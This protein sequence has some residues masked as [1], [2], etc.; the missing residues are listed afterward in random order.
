MRFILT[1]FITPY[2]LCNTCLGGYIVHRSCESFQFECGARAR[3]QTFSHFHCS[4]LA[5]EGNYIFPTH[6]WQH[7]LFQIWRRREIKVS[8]LTVGSTDFFKYGAGGKFFPTHCWQHWLF[9]T[10]RRRGGSHVTG[11]VEG[12]ILL[13]RKRLPPLEYPSPITTCHNTDYVHMNG[14]DRTITVILAKHCIELRDD[15]SLVIR[16]MLEQF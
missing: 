1:N 10:W 13:L 11:E 6:C 15:G 3:T 8:L 7:W 4:Q 16:N 2:R 9:Q 5:P 14:R 12:V